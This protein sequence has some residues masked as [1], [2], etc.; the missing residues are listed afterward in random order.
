[1]PALTRQQAAVLAAVGAVAVAVAFLSPW[2]P[3]ARKAAPD[4]ME[5]VNWA[6]FDPQPHRARGGLYHPPLCGQGRTALLENGWQWITNPPSE[7]TG[8]GNAGY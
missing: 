8:A 6:P 7:N 4:G 2:S 1:M 5:G 3:L